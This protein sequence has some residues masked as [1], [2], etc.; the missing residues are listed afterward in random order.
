[1]KTKKKRRGR[2]ARATQVRWSTYQVERFASRFETPCLHR[3]AD[4]FDPHERWRAA[5]DP[6]EQVTED[7]NVVLRVDSPEIR[8]F[9]KA[10]GEAMVRQM[11]AERSAAREGEGK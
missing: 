1:M 5:I 2:P 3:F 9:A 6:V 11:L 10:L 7:L 4:R 8:A